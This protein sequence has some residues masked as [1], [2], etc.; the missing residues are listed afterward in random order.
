MRNIAE[1]WYTSG[2]YVQEGMHKETQDYTGSYRFVY[3]K[4]IGFSIFHSFQKNFRML[5]SRPNREDS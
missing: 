1:T 2:T 3:Y 4:L 5:K